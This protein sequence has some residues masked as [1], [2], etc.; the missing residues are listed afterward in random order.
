MVFSDGSAMGKS[1]GPG[2]CGAVLVYLTSLM[3]DSRWYIYSYYA[4]NGDCEVKDIVLA[5]TKALVS[6]QVSGIVNDC[7]YIFT[8]SESAIDIFSN[9]NDINRW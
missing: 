9:Q 3:I 7:C 1:V 2:G 5:F 4:E 8:H 6:H